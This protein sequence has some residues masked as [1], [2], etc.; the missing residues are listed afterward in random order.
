MKI[1]IIRFSSF[2]DVVQTFSLPAAI[3]MNFP[4]AQVSLVT[5]QEYAP[6]AQEHRY[7]K[8][9]WGFQRSSGLRGLI[10]LARE[11]KQEGFTHIYDAHNNLRSTLLRYMIFGVKA[12]YHHSMLLRPTYRWKRF[13]LFYLGI[14]R[15]PQP[16][17]GQ[18]ALL[19]PL[20]EWGVSSFLPPPPQV[21]F[22]EETLKQTQALLTPHLI[23]N[24]NAQPTVALAPSASYELK[25]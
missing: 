24:L 17:P 4:Q 22:S 25:R 7:M 3:R 14:N 13:L 8:K 18:E 11:L 16:F 23:S 2:G 9:V 20:R 12:A 1:L 15:Y 19:M 5:A 10:R 21:F 6:L